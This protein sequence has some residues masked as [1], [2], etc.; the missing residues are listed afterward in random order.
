MTVTQTVHTG[1]LHDFGWLEGHD[2]ARPSR[3]SAMLGWHLAQLAYDLKTE[4]WLEAGWR[5]VSIQ[6]ES[7]VVPGP[8]GDGEPGNLLEQAKNAVRPQVAKGVNALLT[9]IAQAREFFGGK[10]T[11]IAGKAVTLLLPQADDTFVV[12]VGFMGTGRRP[13]D[14]LGN[15]RMAHPEGFH[16]GFSAIAAR[17]MGNAPVIRF[18]QAA[19]VLGEAAPTLQSMIERCKSPGSPFRLVLAGHSQGAAV[20]QVFAHQLLRNGVLPEYVSGFGFASPMPAQELGP[21]AGDV[22]LSLFLF[23]DDAFTRVGLSERLGH[24][25]V[26]EA[27]D[28]DRHAVYGLAYAQPLVRQTL[29]L[30]DEV[31]DAADAFTLTLGY[32]DALAHRPL[33]VIAGSLA[34][35]FED[36]RL[37]FLSMAERWVLRILRHVTRG[38][39]QS[40]LDAAGYPP[41]PQKVSAMRERMDALM[42][43]HGG[44]RFSRT[45]ARALAM[46][47]SL[48]HAEP[49][50][51]GIAPYEYIVNQ[52]FDRLTP[53]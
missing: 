50:S 37:N 10:G 26:L 53:C 1:V 33:R 28:A 14:W 32:L 16:E 34:E 48:A 30:L 45:L 13:S 52:A 25:F 42:D 5:D 8:S 36:S 11:Y 23:S 15:M 12:A 18:P 39:E 29:A 7:R 51:G 38:F 35:F 24:C 41:D 22:P 49:G 44:V 20:M 17:F 46:T 47:H 43:G 31:R 4:P 19:N 40:H 21:D 6:L 3:D 2:P 27:T 9:P